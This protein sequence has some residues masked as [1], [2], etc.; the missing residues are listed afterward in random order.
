MTYAL[1]FLAKLFDECPQYNTI[2]ISPLLAFHD[3]VCDLMSGVFNQRPP[4]ILSE[5]NLPSDKTLTFKLV[6]LLAL[7]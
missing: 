5:K 3:R 1:D 7:I 2:H 4:E 6:L